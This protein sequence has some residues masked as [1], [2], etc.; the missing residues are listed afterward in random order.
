MGYRDPREAL[1]AE[2]ESLQRQLREAQEEISAMRERRASRPRVAL[3]GCLGGTALLLPLMTATL[4]GTWMARAEMSRP[5]APRPAATAAA[6]P[7]RGSCPMARGFERFTTALERPATVTEASHFPGVA[8]ASRCT[9]RVAPVAMAGFNCHVEVA[10]GATVVYGAGQTGYAHCDVNGAQP[11][12]A[13]DPDTTPQDGDAKLTLD[14]PG[15][16]VVVEDQQGDT[17]SRVVLSLAHP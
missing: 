3:G 5:V 12:R 10:C 15:G 7:R 13:L 14:I 4:Y 16:R 1:H 2:N 11:V 17:A 8:A 9:V 6:H